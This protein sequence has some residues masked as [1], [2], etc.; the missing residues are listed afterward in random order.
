MPYW[1]RGRDSQTGKPTDPFFSDSDDEAAARA[2]ATTQGM[3]VESVAACDVA[4]LFGE[5]Q[6]PTVGI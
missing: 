5:P 3:V 1:I 6:F 4:P 2:E